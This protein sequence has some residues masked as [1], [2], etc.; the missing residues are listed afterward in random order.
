MRRLCA[1]VVARVPELGHVDLDRVAITFR[2][3]RIRARHGLQA[4]LT[5]LRFEGGSHFTIRRGRRWTIESLRDRQGR[6]LLYILSFYLPR[7]MDH[8][9]AEKLVTVFHELWHISP[10]F[11]GDLRRHAGRCYAHSHSQKQYD[12][13]MQGLVDRWLAAGPDE[14]LYA[15]L[16]LS[17]QELHQRHG[18]IFGVTMPAPRLIRAD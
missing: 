16:R 7:F 10:D 5:P 18:S 17:F 12:A 8:P 15:F 13:A 4:T 3:A 11:D 1:D 9:L 14:D 6:E 2:Q